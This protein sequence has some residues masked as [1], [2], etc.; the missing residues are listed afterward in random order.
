MDV[1][2]ILGKDLI[3]TTDAVNLFLT[4]GAITGTIQPK[5]GF[6]FLFALNFMKSLE[7]SSLLEGVVHRGDY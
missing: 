2:E 1:G 6:E 7:Y 5:A 3:S 4:S